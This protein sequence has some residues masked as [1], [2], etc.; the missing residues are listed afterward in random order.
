MRRYMNTHPHAEAIKT[1]GDVAASAGSTLVIMSHWSEVLT[2]IIALL[3]GLLTL[4]W[5]SIRLIDR[6]QSGR[7]QGKS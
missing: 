7:D 6:F 2:P 3:V 5:W 1:A 4:V